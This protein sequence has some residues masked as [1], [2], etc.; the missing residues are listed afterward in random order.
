MKRLLVFIVLMALMLMCLGGVTSAALANEP[1]GGCPRGG[2]WELVTVASLGLD[3]E[4][5]SGI[6]SLDGNDDGWTC[7]K[8]LPN[9]PEEGSFVFRDNTVQA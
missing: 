8:Q 1:V 7:I 9:F 6:P 2:A 4:T 3:P 5:A